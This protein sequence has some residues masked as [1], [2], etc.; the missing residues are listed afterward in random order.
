MNLRMM[1]ADK[2]VAR[3]HCPPPPPT[4][5]RRAIDDDTY[6]SPVECSLTHAQE[7]EN[8]VRNSMLNMTAE[9]IVKLR[10]M[11]APTLTPKLTLPSFPDADPFEQLHDIRDEDRE[12]L[13]DDMDPYEMN[14][15]DLE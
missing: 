6:N 10:T 14:P 11:E 8:L 4:G 12:S 7:L 2:E 13:L 9:E 15:H 3:P 5:W 1:D